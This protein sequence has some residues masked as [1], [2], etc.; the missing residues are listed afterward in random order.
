MTNIQFPY[1]HIILDWQK[2][3]NID[4][5]CS[6]FFHELAHRSV[7]TGFTSF[8]DLKSFRKTLTSKTVNAGDP[9]FRLRQWLRRLTCGSHPTD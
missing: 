1:R 2:Q 8:I 5:L 6:V 4:A 3:Y 9:A 7:K